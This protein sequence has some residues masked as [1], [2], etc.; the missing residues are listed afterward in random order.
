MAGVT[1][2]PH[3]SGAGRCV[4]PSVGMATGDAAVVMETVGSSS[5]ETAAELSSLINTSGDGSAVDKP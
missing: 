5:S 2:P 3:L 4:E 1:Q